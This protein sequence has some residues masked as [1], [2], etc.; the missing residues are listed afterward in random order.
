MPPVLVPLTPLGTVQI[1]LD[2]V[3]AAARE[4][5][6]EE[7]VTNSKQPGQPLRGVG[8]VS[9]FRGAALGD[10]NVGGPLTC[11]PLTL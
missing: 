8:V 2:T 11:T 1:P 4:K 10:V 3:S 9:V 7:E 5:K 6:V